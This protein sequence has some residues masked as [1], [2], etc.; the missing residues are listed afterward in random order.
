MAGEISV[1]LKGSIGS[2]PAACNGFGTTG[3]SGPTFRL[4]LP[5]SAR[6]ASNDEGSTRR[7]IDSPGALASID[8]PS[9]LRATVI[10]MRVLTTSPMVLELTLETTGVVV[11]PLVGPYFDVFPVD[12][13]VSGIRVQGQGDIEWYA[14]GGV[15]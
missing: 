8:Y 11:R 2:R 6:S 9:N 13:R 12:D 15:V 10:Y 7:T 3:S 5:A 14:A 1:T 4:E